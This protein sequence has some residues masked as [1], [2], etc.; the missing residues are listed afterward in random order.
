MS[1]AST[2]E[3]LRRRARAEASGELICA[4]ATA[5]VHVFLQRGRVAWAIDSAHPF[6]F[7]RFLKE[8]SKID[9]EAFSHVLDSCRRDRLPLGETL[10]AWGLATLS[11]ILAAL[12]Y[13]IQLA[14]AT[15]RSIED[16]AEAIFLERRRFGEY[17]VR[18]TFDLT[19]ILEDGGVEASRARAASVADDANGAS[20]A[21]AVLGSVRGATWV[22]V[23]DD[24]RRVDVA[25]RAEGDVPPVSRDLVQATLD[26]G[27]DFVGLRSPDGSLLGGLLGPRRHLWCALS[28]NANYGAAFAAISGLTTRDRQRH[29]ANGRAKAPIGW[30][31][32]DVESTW[33]AELSQV[34]AYGGDVLAV[35]LVDAVGQLSTAMGTVDLSRAQ[36]ES[37]VARRRA[38]LFGPSR[39]TAGRGELEALGFRYQTLVTGESEVWCFG[40]ESFH[41]EV[42]EARPTLWVLVRREASQGVGWACLSALSRM[43]APR[44]EQAVTT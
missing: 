12:R 1:D 24:G 7:T 15:L 13:Q 31:V 20:Q 39:A 37:I 10:V 11:D 21:R 27:A 36:F 41:G 18:L 29:K 28:A 43:V 2:T 44:G 32:G 9:D 25:A 23:L 34:F 30:T 3:L 42:R 4:S 38:T 19:E 17:D 35:G 40:A 22:Q 16:T 33:A 26:D 5:E 14:L 6:V 8:Q